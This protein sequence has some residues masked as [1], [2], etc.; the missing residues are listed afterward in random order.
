MPKITYEQARQ[1]HEY[2]W[3]I[4]A[5]NDMTG[6]YVDS[7]DLDRLL[8]SPTKATARGCYESQI[9][10]WFQVGP[11]PFLA[12]PA[13]AYLASDP[14]VREIAVRHGVIDDTES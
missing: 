2:L 11:D 10:Y 12:S 9:R 6:G 14:R 7:G 8:R 4:G 1:D 3:S 13:A 5:A